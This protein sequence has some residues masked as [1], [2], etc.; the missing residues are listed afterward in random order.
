MVNPS[1][2]N[3]LFL[4]DVV[5]SFVLSFVRPKDNRAIKTETAVP[6]SPPSSHLLRRTSLFPQ[7]Q[8]IHVDLFTLAIVLW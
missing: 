6:P 1:T 8:R 5:G 7:Q 4:F 3:L 2:L